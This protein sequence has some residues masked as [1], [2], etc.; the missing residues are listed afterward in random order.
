[1][2]RAGLYCFRHFRDDLP[3]RFFKEEQ[4]MGIKPDHT[5]FRVRQPFLQL[6][7]IRFR[8]PEFL[9]E[10]Q[11]DETGGIFIQKREQADLIDEIVEE[12]ALADAGLTDDLVR[13]GVAVAVFCKYFERTVDHAVLFG[14]FQIKKFLI[15]T[16]QYSMRRLTFQ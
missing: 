8:T 3:V 12:Q 1:M 2:R 14:F 15:H 7:I 6:K 9:M 11:Q 16:N 5:G 4:H 10:F 13:A